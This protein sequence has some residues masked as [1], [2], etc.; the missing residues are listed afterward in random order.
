MFPYASERLLFVESFVVWKT[1]HAESKKALTSNEPWNF[2][3]RLKSR[4]GDKIFLP[5]LYFFM[6]MTCTNAQTLIKKL[7]LLSNSKKRG[8]KCCQ[9]CDK[10]TWL[11]HVEWN[12]WNFYSGMENVNRWNI[13]STLIVRN[14]LTLNNAESYKLAVSS[15]LHF[16]T[17]VYQH[18]NQHCLFVWFIFII[19]FELRKTSAKAIKVHQCW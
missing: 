10:E 13:A 15:A 8:N 4:E 17:R 5:T 19:V 3:I 6:F 9:H 2:P 12:R 1:T 11:I 16:L 14:H 18:Q 7:R